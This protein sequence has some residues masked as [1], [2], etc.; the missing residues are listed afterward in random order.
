MPK[1]IFDCVLVDNAQLVPEIQTCSIFNEL[2]PGKLVLFGDQNLPCKDKAH[3]SFP[4]A[5]ELMYNRSLF[6]RLIQGEGGTLVLNNQVR[7]CKVLLDAVQATIKSDS[8]NYGRAVFPGDTVIPEKEPLLVQK[9]CPKLC[10]YD[11]SYLGELKVDKSHSDA[12][13]CY[14]VLG[15]LS[16]LSH[17]VKDIEKSN[18]DRRTPFGMCVQKLLKCTIGIIIPFPQLVSLYRSILSRLKFV[19]LLDIQIGTPSDFMGIEKDI[20][21]LSHLRNS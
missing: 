5:V 10:F 18:P 4:K 12:H 7:L 17:I 20:I 1:V 14:F 21:I 11:L 6:E 19:S 2:R 3:F 8:H 13:E 16:K 9:L 15:L